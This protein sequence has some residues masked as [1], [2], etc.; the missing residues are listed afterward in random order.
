[1]SADHRKKRPPTHIDLDSA[2]AQGP[3]I[4]DDLASASHGEA[5][6]GSS[7]P[8]RLKKK[9][10]VDAFK[11]TET[12][13]HAKRADDSFVV[14]PTAPKSPWGTYQM[15]YDLQLGDID[16][17]TVAEKI[18]PDIEK[19]PVVIIKTFTGPTAE[20]RV[21]AIHRV[22]H[23]DR[24]WIQRRDATT[25]TYLNKNGNEL[26]LEETSCYEVLPCFC[27]CDPGTGIA[28]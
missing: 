18:H 19:N 17:F 12:P 13:K 23:D 10:K 16:Y 28:C 5:L 11:P 25:C 4:A 7:T 3:P 15:L 22:R 6:E 14:V 24:W 26:R 1:M 2:G 8:N 27:R 9:K 21:Q 20:S